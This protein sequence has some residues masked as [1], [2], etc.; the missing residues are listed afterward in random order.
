MIWGFALWLACTNVG[1]IPSKSDA[2]L[3]DHLRS[4]TS[5]EHQVVMIEEMAFDAIRIASPY[6]CKRQRHPK[7]NRKAS[8][9]ALVAYGPNFVDDRRDQQY[10][11][12]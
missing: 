6:S 12:V 3:E 8:L 5:I 7:Q 11:Q 2:W 10:W 9:K 1:K 4:S